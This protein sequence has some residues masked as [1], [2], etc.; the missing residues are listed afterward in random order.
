MGRYKHDSPARARTRRNRQ[1]SRRSTGPRDTTSTRFNA[2]KHGLLAEGVTELDEPETFLA[3]CVKLEGELKPVGEVE[4]FL[5]RRIALGIV[6]LKRAAL[7]EAEFITGQLNPPITESNSNDVLQ[8]IAGMNAKPVVLDPGLPA[9]ISAETMD[10]LANTFS[11]Y[12]TAI[13][14]RIVRDMNQFER[15]QRLRMGENLPL[16][17]SGGVHADEDSVASFGNPSLPLPERKSLGK[18]KTAP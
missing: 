13:H 17:T 8:M 9:R 12:E 5:A 10:A 18:V 11:R 16:T 2:M 1:N 3:F 14:N 6:R 7:V 4:A 15:M